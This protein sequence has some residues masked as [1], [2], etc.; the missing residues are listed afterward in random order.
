MLPYNEITRKS[1]G[2]PAPYP[3][4]RVAGENP[5]YAFLLME[6]Y[7]G[8]VSEVTAINQYLY[9]YF[10][11]GESNAQ[12]AA[13]LEKIAVNE[14]L[15]MEI[16]AKVILLLGGNPVYKGSPNSGGHFW[17]ASYVFYGT[18]LCGRLRGNLAAELQAIQNYRNRIR[19]INDP[20]VKAILE[21]IV[22]DEL[23]HVKLFEAAIKKY[24]PK[25]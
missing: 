9:H 2:D 5:R 24:C 15:H 4:I 19:I 13:M 1:E 22:L 16:L 21:R 6:D 7:A 10:I 3:E 12:V 23:Y 8:T 18:N 17:N 14:M 25:G 11:T 20:Y